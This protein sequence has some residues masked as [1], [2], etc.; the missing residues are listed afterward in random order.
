MRKVDQTKR[1]RCLNKHRQKSESQGILIPLYKASCLRL[2]APVRYLSEPAAL[3][4]LRRRL[5]NHRVLELI[6]SWLARN[7][8]PRDGTIGLEPL[9]AVHLGNPFVEV[10]HFHQVSQTMPQRFDLDRPPRP[11]LDHHGRI[12][13]EN[14]AKDSIF[15]GTNGEEWLKSKRSTFAAHRKRYFCLLSSMQT[16]TGRFHQTIS[17]QS[18][19]AETQ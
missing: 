6:P 19:W 8:R 10:T 7:T 13:D 14:I 4:T 17:I 3:L 9:L 12:Y 2:H 15:D 16:Q 5:A 1:S 11:L 18:Q